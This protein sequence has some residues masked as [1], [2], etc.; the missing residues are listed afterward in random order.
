VKTKEPK[1]QDRPRQKA[2]EQP[3]K[4]QTGTRHIK[5][6]NPEAKKRKHTGG[7]ELLKTPAEMARLVGFSKR[8]LARLTKAK[9]VPVVRIQRLCFYCPARVMA[10]LQRNLEV[11]EVQP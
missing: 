2:V 4:V 3:G 8:T 6:P 10:A 7:G 11:K 1:P 9:L 5:T